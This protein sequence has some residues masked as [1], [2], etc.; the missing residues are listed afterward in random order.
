HSLSEFSITALRDPKSVCIRSEGRLWVCPSVSWTFDQTVA[1][2]SAGHPEHEAFQH[3]DCRHH[4]TRLHTDTTTTSLVLAYVLTGYARPGNVTDAATLKFIRAALI[5]THLRICPH[6]SISDPPVR[7]RFT[8]NCKRTFEMTADQCGCRVCSGRMFGDDE[9]A[10]PVCFTEVQ[11]RRKVA[12]GMTYLYLVTAKSIDERFL[13]GKRDRMWRRSVTLPSE[14]G[15]LDEEWD[16][17]SFES[18]E[19]VTVDENPLDGGRFVL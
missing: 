4:F 7:W 2:R 17:S 18:Y 13:S 10:C 19:T 6:L 1:D 15:R 14:M 9:A 12:N 16:S 5:S 8:S 11:F 3:C